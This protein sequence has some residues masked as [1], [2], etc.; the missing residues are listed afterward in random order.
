[1]DK[2]KSSEVINILKPFTPIK[3]GIGPYPNKEV[4]NY[5]FKLLKNEEEYE[6]YL[7]DP[8]KAL[9]NEGIDTSKLDID[10]FTELAKLLKRRITGKVPELPGIGIQ[11]KETKTQT[12]V[13]FN[14]DRYILT[15]YENRVL[16]VKGTKS[17]TTT[18]EFLAQN[19]TFAGI[20]L[21]PD[22]ILR[23]ELEM[24]FFPAQPLVTPGLIEK[25]KEIL[26]KE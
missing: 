12:E 3:R 26:E 25:I 15:N 20:G 11:S 18:G 9:K 10:M 8:I 19:N 23:Y 7:K 13:N 1:M 4:P 16:W 6:R 22:T 21:D 5:M 14:N 24:L 2:Q 17:E